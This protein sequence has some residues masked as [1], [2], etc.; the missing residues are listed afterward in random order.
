MR[1]L[2][3]FL[4]FVAYLTNPTYAQYIDSEPEVTRIFTETI[5]EFKSKPEIC[6]FKN[7][8]NKNC[9]KGS[10]SYTV[11]LVLINGKKHIKIYASK[12]SATQEFYSLPAPFKSNTIKVR[13]DTTLLMSRPSVLD[14]SDQI[15]YVA[16]LSKFTC[17]KKKYQ[18]LEPWTA[19]D[20]PP[21]IQNNPLVFTKNVTM[22]YEINLSAQ[23]VTVKPKLLGK[24]SFDNRKLC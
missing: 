18:V 21:G 11:R 2:F 8:N 24:M 5:L 3:I 19:S 14:S 1:T 16:T 13:Q 4:W 9:E 23:T 10:D 15:R 12:M 20:N 17:P 7:L 6:D 22:I